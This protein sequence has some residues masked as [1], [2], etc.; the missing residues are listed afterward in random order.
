MFWIQVLKYGVIAGLAWTS[1]YMFRDAQGERIA[2][3]MCGEA[4]CTGGSW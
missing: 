4:P 3:S 2:P 1:G